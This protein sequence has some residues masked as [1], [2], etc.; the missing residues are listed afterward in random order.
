MNLSQDILQTGTSISWRGRL[1]FTF[2]MGK[3][4][5]RLLLALTFSSI[6]LHSRLL[7]FGLVKLLRTQRYYALHAAGLLTS[8]EKGV[9]ICGA[10]GCGKTTLTIGMIRHG[11]GYLSDDAVLLRLGQEGVNAL[12]FRQPFSIDSKMAPS[13]ADLPLGKEPPPTP[14]KHKR[15]LNIHEAFPNRYAP[16]C[17]PAILLFPKIVSC[18]TSRLTPMTR[19]HAISQLLEQ[20]N[21]EFFD[22]PTMEDHLQLLTQLVKQ[23]H[24]Y[25]LQ[26]GLDL[27]N[28]PEI[29][30]GLLTKAEEIT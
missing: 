19:S 6:P 21:P 7:G 24:S 16:K 30:E 23:C 18:F 29:L 20:S 11:W 15:K 8:T 10:S 28:Q 22:R 3:S 25:E 13:Y 26:A 4:G 14:G 9:L 17:F 12:V 5:A 1:S 27:V 2:R